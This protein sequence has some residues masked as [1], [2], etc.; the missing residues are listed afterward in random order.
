MSNATDRFVAQAHQRSP[1]A[2]PEG[3]NL[4]KAGAGIKRSSKETAQKMENIIIANVSGLQEDVLTRLPN[5][6]TI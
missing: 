4:L 5:V 2:D 1:T 3:N 6:E